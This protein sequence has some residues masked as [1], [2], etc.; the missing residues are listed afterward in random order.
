M[1]NRNKILDY[2]QF[3]C[4]NQIFFDLHVLVY[5][6]YHVFFLEILSCFS[7]VGLIQGTSV[8]LICTGRFT[9][10]D[11]DFAERKEHNFYCYYLC[12]T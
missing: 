6:L 2:T 7:V 11:F 4:V 10:F 12:R 5:M 3:S 1:V 8:S 9:S